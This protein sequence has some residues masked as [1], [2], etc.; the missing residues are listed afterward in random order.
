MK[1]TLKCS[2]AGLLLMV[3]AFLYAQEK[4]PL[5]KFYEALDGSCLEFTCEYTFTPQTRADAAGT[6][7]VTGQARIEIQG[8]AYVFEGNGL[9]VK[10]DGKSV[11][12]IDDEAREIIYESMPETLSEADFLQNPAYLLRGLKDNFKVAR[13]TRETDSYGDHISDDF[14]L[15]PLVKCGIVKCR[16]SF[17]VC[18]DSLPTVFLEMTDGSELKV[19]MYEDNLMPKKPLSYFAPPAPSSF[20]SSWIVTDIR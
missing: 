13:T 11:C 17:V 12:F 3:S 7:K 15:V 6:G 2:V 1:N 4:N 14:I 9:V 5:E 19:W 18:Q 8:D 10:S 16:L 20:D